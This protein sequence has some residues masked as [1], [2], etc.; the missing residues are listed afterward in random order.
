[1]GGT[2]SGAWT[3]TAKAREALKEKYRRDHPDRP[4]ADA[5]AREY[6]RK[7]PDERIDAVGCGVLLRALFSRR[8]GGMQL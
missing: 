3:K 2:G 5:V 6:N 7:H 4:D 1:M 8:K